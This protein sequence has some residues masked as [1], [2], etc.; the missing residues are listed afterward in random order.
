MKMKE[1]PDTVLAV[2]GVQKSY[3]AVRALQGITLAIGE[4]EICGLIG[5]NGSGKTTFFDVCTGL[6]R[7]DTGSIV[8]DGVEISGWTMNRIARQGRMLRSFQRTVVF[9]EVSAV[10]NLVTAGQMF[11]FPSIRST[12]SL[13]PA[14]GRRVHD[15]RKRALELIDLVG[16]TH[17]RTQAAGN[18]SIGQQKLLQFAMMLMSEPRIILLDEPL[19]GVN[20]T[21]FAHIVEGIK[22]ANREL[23]VTFVVIEHNMDAMLDLCRRIVVFDH[24]EMLADA[25]PEVIVKDERVVEA[26]LGG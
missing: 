25:E 14:A 8:L 11:A 9:S 13:G 3:G 4:G 21:L 2:S 18:L 10:E 16:L 20:P 24:G 6:Q 12:F 5:P 17:V 22:R 19:A 15:L 1:L 23:G 7:A 26:Y